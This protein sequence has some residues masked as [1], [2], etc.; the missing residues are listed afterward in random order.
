M[1]EMSLAFC[2]LQ[3]LRLYPPAPATMRTMQSPLTLPLGPDGRSLCVP[4]GVSVV[5]PIWYTIVPATLFFV[6]PVIGLHAY[7]SQC[8]CQSRLFKHISSI[9]FINF[10]RWVHRATANYPDRPEAFDPDRF[11]DPERAAKVHRSVLPQHKLYHTALELCFMA[12]IL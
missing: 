1:L 3:V 6:T 10:F 2:C 8:G 12:I 4:A 7:Q 5:I 9:C 11:F